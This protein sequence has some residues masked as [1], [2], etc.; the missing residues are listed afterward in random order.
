M[1]TEQVAVHFRQDAKSAL[2]KSGLKL[3]NIEWKKWPQ[4][5]GNRL[6]STLKKSALKKFRKSG[7]RFLYRIIFPKEGIPTSELSGKPTYCC[8]AASIS[9]E[10]PSD[11]LCT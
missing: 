4:L 7:V 6:E 3:D 9:I 10:L 2:K 5:L 11:L 8:T 1:V